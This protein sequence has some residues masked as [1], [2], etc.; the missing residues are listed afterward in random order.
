MNRFQYQ[1]R[2]FEL[3]RQI[4][5]EEVDS[6]F[7]LPSLLSWRKEGPGYRLLFGEFAEYAAMSVPTGIYENYNTLKLTITALLKEIDI[8]DASNEVHVFTTKERDYN[9]CK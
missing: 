1:E 9:L 4:C 2:T 8:S 7:V 6:E 5:K 3:I